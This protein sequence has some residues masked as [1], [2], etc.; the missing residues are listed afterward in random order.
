MLGHNDIKTALRDTQSDD[1]DGRAAMEALEKSQSRHTRR[2]GGKERVISNWRRS[3][4]LLP[5]HALYQAQPR[6]ILR[7]SGFQSLRDTAQPQSGR[8]PTVEP[9]MTGAHPGPCVTVL[10]IRGDNTADSCVALQQ[11]E[12]AAHEVPS[13]KRL[14]GA[15]GRA[16]RG[17]GLV[18]KGP[19]F[20]V[21][22][23]MGGDLAKSSVEIEAET[24][25]LDRRQGTDHDQRTD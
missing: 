12:H 11:L 8:V 24:N 17:R 4:H 2:P 13:V 22:S 10:E 25:R 19:S 18:Q 3:G 6:P 23:Q 9:A 5:Q 20:A 21:T 15:I 7:L 14:D 1:K 16:L